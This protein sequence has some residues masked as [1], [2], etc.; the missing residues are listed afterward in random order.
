M[1]R[2]NSYFHLSEWYE[3]HREKD[4][5]YRFRVDDT[6]HKLFRFYSADDI[7]DA[8]EKYRDFAA[9]I[10]AFNHILAYAKWSSEEEVRNWYEDCDDLSDL[11]D[12][13]L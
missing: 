13:L 6:G 11:D 3:I 4:G 2:G 10:A 12:L 8:P 1:V 7:T 9:I 5:W